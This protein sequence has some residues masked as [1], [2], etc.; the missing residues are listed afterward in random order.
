VQGKYCV[1]DATRGGVRVRSRRENGTLIAIISAIEAL[2][3]KVND[4]YEG[5][6]MMVWKLESLLFQK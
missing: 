4:R 6:L 5:E 1:G 2:S 3:Q